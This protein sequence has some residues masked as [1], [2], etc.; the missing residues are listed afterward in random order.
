MVRGGGRGGGGGEQRGG[1]R[2][3]REACGDHRGGT[4]TVL[5]ARH[6]QHRAAAPVGGADVTRDLA[7]PQGDRAGCAAPVEIKYLMK[8]TLDIIQLKR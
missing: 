5:A 3:E 1:Q 2:E 6:H 8:S 4:G 7:P